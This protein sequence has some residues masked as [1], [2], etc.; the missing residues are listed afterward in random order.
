MSEVNFAQAGGTYQNGGL[1]LAHQ[2]FLVSLL[3]DKVHVD[4]LQRLLVVEKQLKLLLVL[5]QQTQTIS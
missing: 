2:V 5:R 3:Y 4:K 1:V